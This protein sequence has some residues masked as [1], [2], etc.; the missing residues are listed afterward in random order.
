MKKAPLLWKLKL[1]MKFYNQYGNL[2]SNSI[3]KKIKTTSQTVIK[4]M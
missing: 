4:L 1:I 2:K 3:T